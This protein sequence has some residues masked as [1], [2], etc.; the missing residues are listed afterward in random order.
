MS[1]ISTKPYLVRAI[2][3]WC[4]DSGYT[5]YVAVQVDESVRVPRE[6]V[7]Q[8]EIVLNVSALATQSLQMD[9]E[10]ISFRARF[11]GVPRDIWV[12]MAN[13]L[14]IYARE[15]GQGMAFETHAAD[16]ANDAEMLEPQAESTESTEPLRPVGPPSLSLAPPP[17]TPAPA[18]PVPP[19]DEPPPP[20][21]DRPRLTRI[22]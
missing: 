9:N 22:K 14:A 7:N 5:P 13:V 11:G 3:D 4:T 8:G 16:E 17:A 18:A 6:F 2:F 20:G 21:G 10:G 15:N 19:P 12:P 1:E